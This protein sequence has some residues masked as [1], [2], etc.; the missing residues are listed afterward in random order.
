MREHKVG[1]AENYTDA[2][3]ATLGLILFMAFWCIATVFGVVW[4]MV[5]ATAL[6]WLRSRLI[7]RDTPP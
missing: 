3:L 1:R 6:D 7:R 2:F 5:I 4:V